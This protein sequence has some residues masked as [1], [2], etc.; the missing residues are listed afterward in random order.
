MIYH[1]S[2]SS[3]NRTLLLVKIV[4]LR[5]IG[6]SDIGNEFI[7]KYDHLRSIFGSIPHSLSLGRNAIAINSSSFFPDHV[8]KCYNT[9]YGVIQLKYYILHIMI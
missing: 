2:S 5:R 4:R 6:F 1:D 7:D 3:N 9:N 8:T